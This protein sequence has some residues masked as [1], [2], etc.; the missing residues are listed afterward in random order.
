[1]TNIENGSQEFIL[2]LGKPIQFSLIFISNVCT[3]DN[4]RRNIGK[5]EIRISNDG[6]PWSLD[7]SAFV[8]S[9]IYEGGFFE[10]KLDAPARYIAIRR[11]GS[12]PNGIIFFLSEARIFEHKNLL[13]SV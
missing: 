3:R 2:D 13:M 9:N 10:V 5:V 4:W 8:I 6:S 11:I 1:M 12:S 7:N